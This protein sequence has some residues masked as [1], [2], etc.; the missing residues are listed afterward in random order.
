VRSIFVGNLSSSVGENVIRSMFEKYGTVECVILARD[1]ITGQPR[2]LAFVEMS[3]DAAGS[4]AM[5]ELN[6]RQV[7]GRTVTVKEA[8]PEVVGGLRHSGHDGAKRR[9]DGAVVPSE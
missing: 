8:R 4:R 6:G 7:D 9:N 5:H 2:G 3:G 1:R